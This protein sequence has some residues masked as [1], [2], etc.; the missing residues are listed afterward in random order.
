MARNGVIVCGV[1]GSR[2]AREA[3][4]TADRLAHGLGLTIIAAHVVAP[5]AVPAT[6]EPLLQQVCA[7]A[8]LGHVE[9]HVLA[10]RP[11]E[12][13]AELADGRQAELIVVGSRGHRLR[14]VA[15]IGGVASE[16][17]GLAPC[18]VLVVP[19]LALDWDTAA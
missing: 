3:L 5:V 10:G 2:V 15:F 4:R 19:A 17:I 13:L 14:Q 7:D 16:L 12:Q 6:G 18:P 8:G 11:A 1:D 9:Q